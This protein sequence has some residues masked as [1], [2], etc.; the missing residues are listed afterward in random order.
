MARKVHLL[1]CLALT[2]HADTNRS[3]PS[4]T[5]AMYVAD[6]ERL[7]DVEVRQALWREDP[8]T[9]YVP[10]SP[11]N[12]MLVDDPARDMAITRWGYAFSPL[13]GDVRHYDYIS[14]CLDVGLFPQGRFVS[15]YGWHS[16]PALPTWQQVLGGAE[17]YN[18][19]G[20]VVT[21]RQHHAGGQPEMLQQMALHLPPVQNGLPSNATPAEVFARQSYFSMVS[22]A[23]CIGQQSRFYRSLRNVSAVQTGG[24]M[25]W[26]L[27]DVWQA[28]T[29]AMIDYSGRRKLL[30]FETGQAFADLSL[31]GL[32]QAGQP[33]MT[34]SLL[35]DLPVASAGTLTVQSYDLLGTALANEPIASVDLPVTVDA[36]SS[37]VVARIPLTQL[38][39]AAPTGLNSSVARLCFRVGHTA[40]GRTGGAACMVEQTVYLGSLASVTLAPTNIT[41][42]ASQE[43]AAS[44]QLDLSAT[45][46]SPWTFLEISD[47][48]AGTLSFNGL[49]LLPGETRSVLFTAAS[50]NASIPLLL[51]S[52]RVRSV[53][54]LAH[55]SLVML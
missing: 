2:V 3:V 39:P 37:A 38:V 8:L 15:E 28:A 51:S 49:L 47:S 34:V 33:N 19:T 26:M 32:V 5:S 53:A 52:L 10:S 17:D 45:T 42:V 36:F 21:H 44:V 9:W 54:P 18:F 4:N 14:P 24:A 29:W 7:F 22:Q 23:L 25:V 13:Y 20:D 46:P 16:S 35:S 55:T 11:S 27:N 48:S 12:G 50:G 43:E 40:A 6:L 30:F 31:F 1:T 41:V